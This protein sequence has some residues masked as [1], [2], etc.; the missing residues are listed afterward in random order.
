MSDSPIIQQDDLGLDLATKSEAPVHGVLNLKT[1]RKNAE[2]ETIH[3]ALTI[4]KNNISAAA[5][6]L[7]VTRP[8]L[9]DMMRKYNLSSDAN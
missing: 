4:S 1:A 3:S 9:Y 2:I 8:T 7:G 5:K 6:L